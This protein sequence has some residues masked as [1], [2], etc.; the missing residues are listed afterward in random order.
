MLE[1][2]EEGVLAVTQVTLRPKVRFAEGTE[3][4]PEQ[5]DKLHH[6][7]HEHC[8]IANSVKTRVSVE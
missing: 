5:L 1:K 4:T 7:A 8:F 2:N 6:K 3:V